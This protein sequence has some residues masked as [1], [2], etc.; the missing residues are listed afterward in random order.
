MFKKDDKNKGQE[1]KGQ[2][3]TPAAAPVA[4]T[5]AA[6]AAKKK[7]YEEN[8]KGWGFEPG[9][10][11]YI[12]MGHPNGVDDRFAEAIEP[13]EKP[14]HIKARMQNPKTGE[15]QRSVVV[16]DNAHLLLVA[17]GGAGQPVN[18]EHGDNYVMDAAGVYKTK[19]TIE[20]E[21]LKNKAKQPTEATPEAG[22]AEAQ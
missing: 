7:W 21:L 8:G 2:V 14:N 5:P 1:V 9:D 11:V 17:K 12:G 19:A 6:P 3:A 10:V 15:L 16:I 20:K 18:A 4:E 13:S 22:L